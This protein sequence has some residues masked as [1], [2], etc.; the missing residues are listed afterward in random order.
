MSNVILLLGLILTRV[1][2]T[3]F[4]FRWLRFRIDQFQTS[5]TGRVNAI[6]RWKLEFFCQLEKSGMIAT[7]SHQRYSF[8]F[9]V[10]WMKRVHLVS[11]KNIT[12]KSPSKRLEQTWRCESF[13]IISG[14]TVNGR[15]RPPLNAAWWSKS[16]SSRDRLKV[17][18]FSLVTPWKSMSHVVPVIVSRVHVPALTD[19]CHL[20][21]HEVWTSDSKLLE[22][23]TELLGS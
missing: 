15:L 3:S 12:N 1:Y 7:S 8:R 23:E 9:V 10:M 11:K 14:E 17:V 19:V 13:F 16:F 18:R 22:L 21:L 2:F 5:E 4:V 20:E 6:Q